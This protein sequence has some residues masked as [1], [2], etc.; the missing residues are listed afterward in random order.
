[1]NEMPSGHE[2][3]TF[4][5]VEKCPVYQINKKIA[6]KN[7]DFDSEY[8]PTTEEE[9]EEF[10]SGCPAISKRR[11]KNPNLEIPEP[12]YNVQYV[13]PHNSLMGY[14]GIFGLKNYET[15]SREQWDQYPIY[16]KHTVFEISDELQNVRKFE[17]GRRFFIQD[18][19]REKGNRRYQKGHYTKALAHFEKALSCIRW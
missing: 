10:T 12:S 11:N 8:E 14:K 3:F 6:N 17:I 13:S 19:I 16:L 2:G 4:D 7:A 15:I 18:A 5:D 1:M 9:D